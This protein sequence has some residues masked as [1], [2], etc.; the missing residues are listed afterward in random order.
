MET[1]LGTS[2]RQSHYSL[3]T[4]YIHVHKNLSYGHLRQEIGGDLNNS[5]WTYHVG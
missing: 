5:G 3:S 1:S 2:T 4:G